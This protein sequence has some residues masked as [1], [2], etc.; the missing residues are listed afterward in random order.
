MRDKK[1]ITMNKDYV[2]LR[3]LGK[4]IREISELPIQ[5][6]KRA[7][8]TANND[9]KDARPM[10]YMD[11]LPW[12]EISK[13]EEMQLSCEDTFLRNVEYSLRQRLYRWDHFPCDMVV[14]KRVEIPMSIYNLNYGINIVEKALY[15]DEESEIYSHQYKNQL[16]DYEQLKALKD[17]EVWVDTQS[18]QKHM[19]ICTDI[20]DDILPCRLMGAEMSLAV[21]DRIAQM[22]P[23]ESILFDLIDRPE[24]MIAVVNRLVDLSM[25]TV[26]QCEK[27]GILDPGLNLTH[28]TGAYT[29]DLPDPE[30]G[31]VTSKNVWAFGMAQIFSTVSPAMHDTF[32]IDLV[33]PLFERFGLLYYGCCEPLDGKIDIIRKIRNVRKISV[34]PWADVNKCA[35][36]I[37]KDYVF[38]Y[39]PHPAHVTRGSLRE[40]AAREEIKSAINA[41]KDNSSPIEI[42]L[43]D[44]STV[45]YN[46]LVLDEWEKMAMAC[47]LS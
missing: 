29:N 42:I 19:E 2:I 4:K 28:C 18:D 44:V 27:L 34:S 9:L 16:Q 6:E 43:K 40:D 36:S 15:I 30:N 38:S 3:E 8:W 10:V 24:F 22:K 46:P 17:D 12:H 45:N 26:D 14:E 13:V 32:E 23:V 35:S 21:W 25:S 5:A 7:L 33:K 47:V 1:G 39:K 31:I 41:A 11:Q 37:G 20:F